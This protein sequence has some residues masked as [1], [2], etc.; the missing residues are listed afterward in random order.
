MGASL[1]THFQM[2]GRYNTVVNERLYAVCAELS[3]EEYRQEGVGSFRSIHKTLNHILLGDQI[4]MTRF[5]TS[6]VTS[7][8]ALATVLYDELPA[9]REARA[10]EDARIEAFL[11]GLTEAYLRGNVRYVNSAGKLFE[12]QICLV[13]QHMFNHQTHHRGQIHVMLAQ[14]GRTVNLDMHRAIH[15]EWKALEQ[16]V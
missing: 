1:V 3:D 6:E 11:S 10:L 4:W 7:T 9:L 13:L 8:P 2:L 14:F 16:T 5:T 12:D 15:P